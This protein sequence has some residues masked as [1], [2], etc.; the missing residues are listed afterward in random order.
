MSKEKS[1][2]LFFKIFE[3]ILQ[4]EKLYGRGNGEYKLKF[5][6]ENMKDAD[7]EVVKTIVEGLLAIPLI[8]KSLKK[9]VK[10]FGCC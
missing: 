2:E 1:R 7:D 8:Q 10:K 6:L 3:L 9:M 4:S 5:V